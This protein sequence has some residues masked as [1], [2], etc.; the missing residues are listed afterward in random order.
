M[1]RDDRLGP[2]RQPPPHLGGR[3]VESGPVDIG[4]DRRRALEDEAV[5]ARDEGDRRGNR[6]VA[7]A[8]ADAEQAARKALDLLGADPA[9]AG[10]GSSADDATARR[11]LSA[12]GQR[13]AMCDL[14]VGWPGVPRRAGGWPGA[15]WNWESVAD[16]VLRR[17][18]PAEPPVVSE[19][20]ALAW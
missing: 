9:P 13:C 14:V 15:R 20:G 1:H 7:G 12:G 17:S 19:S 8:E 5:R 2:R 16:R 6:L 11:R 18:E 3:Q 4:E 10:E